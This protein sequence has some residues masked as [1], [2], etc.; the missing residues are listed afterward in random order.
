MTPNLSQ[1]LALFTPMTLLTF[2][3]FL[4]ACLQKALTVATAV[5]VLVGLRPTALAQQVI[6][7]VSP[8][9]RAIFVPYTDGLSFDV[10]SDAGTKS[11]AITLNLNGTD[12]TAG[13]VPARL[14]IRAPECLLKTRPVAPTGMASTPK[15]TKSTTREWDRVSR[16][17]G[18]LPTILISLTWTTPARGSASCSVIRCVRPTGWELKWA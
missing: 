8:A 7:N 15:P 6:A 4:R 12:Q 14:L 18:S 11:N 10:Q 13:L 1:S 3:N 2:C 9:D 16:R 5:V 17:K